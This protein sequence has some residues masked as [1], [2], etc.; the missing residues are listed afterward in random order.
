MVVNIGCSGDGAGL[1]SS[2]VFLVSMVLRRSRFLSFL[3]GFLAF[4]YVHSMLL[5]FAPMSS[6]LGT[7]ISSG[8][9]LHRPFPDSYGQWRKTPWHYE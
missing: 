9:G 2:P 7:S 5:L 6:T 3:A 1:F 4:A 8:G